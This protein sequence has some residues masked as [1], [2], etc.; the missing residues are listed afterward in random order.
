MKKTKIAI[1]LNIII[2][3]FALVGMTLMLLGVQVM[4]PEDGFS[5]NKI[6]MFRFYTVDTNVLMGIISLIFGIYEIKFIKGKIEKIPTKLYI[7][8]LIST[9]GVALTFIIVVFYLAPI[10]TYG[11]LSMFR[12]ANLFFHFLV[13]V[14]SIIVFCFLEKTKEIEFKHTFTGI[15]TMVLYSVFYLINILIHSENGKV[16]PKY[17]WYWFVQNGVWTMVIVVPIIFVLTYIISFT[18]WKLNRNKK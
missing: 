12:N 1:T 11:Y 18:L 9:V 15:S 10:A 17:D 14:L 6:S 3:I 7:L 5:D 2:T 8:K 13:P 16:S 4:G